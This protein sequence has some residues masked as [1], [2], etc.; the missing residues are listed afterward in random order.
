[1]NGHVIRVF[2]RYLIVSRPTFI[3][4]V[5]IT[6]L[7][8]TLINWWSTL[9]LTLVPLFKNGVVKKKKTSTMQKEM[10]WGPPGENLRPRQTN[11]NKVCGITVK[12]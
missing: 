5:K 7:N 9:H 10:R 4:G 8:L 2:T 6:I 12:Q 11:R 1:M 3:T